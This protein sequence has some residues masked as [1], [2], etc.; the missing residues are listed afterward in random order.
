LKS[1]LAQD[2]TVDFEVI[3][4]D[5]G[6]SDGSADM[7]RERFAEVRLIAND[8]NVG[9]A[10]AQNQAFA[11]STGRYVLLMNPDSF[12]PDSDALA[13][14]VRYLDRE[15]S[16]AILGLRVLNPDGS[17]QFSARR[18]PTFGAALFRHTILGRLFPKNRFVREY[19]M[20]DWDHSEPRE[21]D[22]VSGCAMVIRRAAL[23]LIGPLDERF[24][25]YC[26]DVDICYR[27][28]K[29]GLS[30]RYY[31]SVT[32]VHRIGGASDQDP[33]R[34]IY[35]FHRSMFRFYLKHYARG[36]RILLLPLVIVGLALRAVGF[37][38]RVR[39]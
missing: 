14:I 21:V 16:V 36:A 10:R 26:E 13:K 23:E 19:V 33:Y 30:V 27:A 37:A 7:V 1:V 29:K 35:H 5:N 38:L 34:M 28:R 24:Y 11:S 20:A 15:R 25:M 39:R 9:F 17:L 32:C 12:L 2:G 3:V 22:W 6:S 18:F 8:S 4:V 31:P